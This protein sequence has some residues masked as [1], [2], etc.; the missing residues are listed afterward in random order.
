[1]PAIQ[2]RADVGLR[3]NSGWNNPEPEIVLA[4]NSRDDVQDVTLGNDM[5]LRDTEGRPALLLDKTEDNN[6]SCA[7]DTLHPPV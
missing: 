6:A 5:N 4:V 3:P 2:P 7:I 1:M